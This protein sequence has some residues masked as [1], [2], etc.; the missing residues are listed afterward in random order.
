MKYR[1]I[2]TGAVVVSASEICGANWVEEKE[3]KTTK[4]AVKKNATVRK[5]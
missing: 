5:N 3:K 4:K 2:K 1:N